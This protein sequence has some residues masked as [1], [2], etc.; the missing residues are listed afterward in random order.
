M[1]LSLVGVCP[2]LL[3]VG[4]SFLL[5]CSGGSDAFPDGGLD[6]T[7]KDGAHMDGQGDSTHLGDASRDGS[8]DANGGDVANDVVTDTGSDATGDASDGGAAAATSAQIQAVRDAADATV[9]DGGA[10]A[11]AD[12][13]SLDLPI[14]NAIVTY[15]KPLIGGD[16]AGFFVQAQQVGPAVFIAVDPTTLTPAPVAGDEVSFHV[17]SVNVD[18]GLREATAITGFA[19]ASEGNSLSALVQDLSSAANL[20]SNLDGF[21]SELSSVSGTIVGTFGGSG[22][23]FVAAEL[24]TAGVTAATGLKLRLPSTLQTSLDLEEG[25]VV[26]VTNTPMWR[27]YAQ[28]QPS[29]WA[30][31]DIAV[32]SCPAPQVI[33][34]VATSPT[35]VTVTFDRNISASILAD[36]SQFGFTGGLTASAAIATGDVATVTTAT[37]SAGSYTVTVASTVKD[38]LGTAV[39]STANTATFSG[40]VPVA[41]VQINE[42]NPNLTGS[43]DLVELLVLTG[44]S[45]GG[46]TLQQDL[47][48]PTVALATLPAINFAA[49]DLVVVHMTPG[50][51][52]TE[53]T[54]KGDC[55]DPACYPGAWDVAGGTTGI[56]FSNQ[57]LVVLDPAL[58]IQDAVAFVKSGSTTSTFPANLQAIQTA[59]AW[60]PADCGGALCTYTSTPTAQAVSADWSTVANTAAGASIARAANGNTKQATDWA[61]TTSSS[62]GASNP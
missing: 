7:Q 5:A 54:T 19:R 1:K 12:A 56:T 42:V 36:G 16:V 13:G 25:C 38:E 32:V 62:F 23:G 21:E 58:A 18:G 37:Q 9:A 59:A 28:A 44:G 50:T 60:L 22:T 43:T 49:G 29:A 31:A 51:V 14:Q 45:L 48:A 47:S 10:D 40:Y 35:S 2:V 57:V 30:S 24:T 52:T 27:F 15:T 8:T 33:S 39:S 4:C 55:T 20:V 41:V 46:L 11:G 17:V 53:T 34:A 3:A 61:I 26:N 6:A